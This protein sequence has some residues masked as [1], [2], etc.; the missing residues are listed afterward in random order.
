MNTDLAGTGEEGITIVNATEF[1]DEFEL[2][3]K[4][5]QENNYLKAINARGKA[6]NSDHYFFTEK[7]VP[8]FFFYTQGG[9]GAYHDIFDLPETL[10]LTE[11]EDLFK[12]IT[13]FFKELIPFKQ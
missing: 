13:S 12:L 6:A 11:H 3:K 10:P 9:I 8:S 1:K 7:G 5:N 2:I 4:I